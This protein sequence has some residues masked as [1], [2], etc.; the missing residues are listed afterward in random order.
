VSIAETTTRNPDDDDNVIGASSPHNDF[1]GISTFE[2]EYSAAVERAREM[3]N[4]YVVGSNHVPL[5]WTLSDP[6]FKTVTKIL[7]RISQ[8]EREVAKIERL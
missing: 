4:T 7:W 5:V 8:L 6:K 1:S 2:A 3:D